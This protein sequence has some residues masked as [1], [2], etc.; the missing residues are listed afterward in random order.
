M[1]FLSA[2]GSGAVGAVGG[3]LIGGP[4]GAMAGFGIGVGAA[5][6]GMSGS[7]NNVG[8]WGG[9]IA[10]GLV[11]F[12]VGG[13]IGGL[14]GGALGALFGNAVQNA[15]QQQPQ[16]QYPQYFPGGGF[17]GY[18]MYGGMPGGFG[19][20]GMGQMGGFGFPM[21][22]YGMQGM[23]QQMGGFGFMGFAGCFPP[24][25]QQCCPPCNQPPMNG[26]GQL[27]GGQGPGQPAAYTTSGGYKVSMDGHTVRITDPSGKH[28]IEHSGDPHEYVDG[29][30]IKDWDEKTRSVVLGDGTRITMN[31]TD[32]HGLITDTTIYD[33][34][35]EIKYDNNASKLQGVNFN[36]YQTQYDA[37]NQA[38]GETAY[39]GQDQSGALVYKNMFKQAENLSVTPY[40]RDL[41]VLEQPKAHH[42][43]RRNWWQTNAA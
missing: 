35:Q 7:Q 27:T 33:G 6:A 9:A 39:F 22:G 1:S 26:G 8:G 36:P 17:G 29:K 2:L 5:A 40:N 38:A 15:N 25:Q 34:A 4:I 12:A 32:A 14:A 16:C 10:G 24:P 37:R 21:G 13:P 11:G 30:H 20:Y 43:H 3:F 42:H 41:S 28:T 19:G 31:A 23:G 18:G